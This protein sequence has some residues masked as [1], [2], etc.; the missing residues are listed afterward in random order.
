MG[1]KKLVYGLIGL[2]LVSMAATGCSSEGRSAGLGA[3]GGAAAGVGGYEY[4]A[5]RE[6]QR[7]EEDLRSGKIDQR[8]YEIRRDQLERSSI[9]R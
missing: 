9:F 5:H 2:F 8:E 6:K 3:L 1:M 4:K 7:L